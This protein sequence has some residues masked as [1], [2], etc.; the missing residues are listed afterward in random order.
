MGQM[1][2]E[3]WQFRAKEGRGQLWVGVADMV[4]ERYLVK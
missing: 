3:S 1:I 2:S 4:R